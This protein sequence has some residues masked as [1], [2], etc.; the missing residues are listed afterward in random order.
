MD[1]FIFICSPAFRTN[2]NCYYFMSCKILSSDKS[3]KCK[4]PDKYY[5]ST[6]NYNNTNYICNISTRSWN[7]SANCYEWVNCFV[8]RRSKSKILCLFIHNFF[9]ISSFYYIFFETL[10]KIKNINIL[11]SRQRSFRGRLSNYSV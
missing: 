4:F 3:W 9:N 5:F 11:R 8:V 6:I 7:I 10:S 2:E 1:G